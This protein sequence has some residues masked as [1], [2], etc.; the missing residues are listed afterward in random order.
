MKKTNVRH[1]LAFALTLLAASCAQKK[2]DKT[3]QAL[4]GLWLTT[5]ERGRYEAAQTGGDG[6]CE[7]FIED[8]GQ[9]RK[10]V[11][12][13]FALKIGSEGA[14][15]FCNVNQQVSSEVSCRPVA[16]KIDLRSGK[17][18]RADKGGLLG[19]DASCDT[20]AR[21]NETELNVDSF[22]VDAKGEAKSQTGSYF[23]IDEAGFLVYLQAAENC[24]KTIEPAAP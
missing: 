3:E 24:R 15:E 20:S 18:E 7:Y 5:E 12:Q 22:C 10:V 1:G 13:S 6:V 2:N 4:P 14:Q 19:A 16:Q 11:R 17:V 23:R 9:D 21:A 8:L